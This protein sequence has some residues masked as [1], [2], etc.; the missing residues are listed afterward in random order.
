MSNNKILNLIEPTLFDQT[1]HSYGYVQSL[2]AA[3]KDLEFDL[4]IWLD[5]RGKSLLENSSCKS[6]PY[7]YRPLRQVQKL[8]LYWKLNRRAEIIFISTT[9]LWDLKILRFY[10]KYF[11][12]RA[13]IVLH[14]HQFKQVPAKIKYLQQIAADCSNIEILVPTQKLADFFKAQGFTQCMVI[15]CPTFSPKRQV[16]NT[17]AQFNKILYAGAARRDKGFPT[18]VSLLQH[19]REQKN[20]LPFEIQVSAPNSQRY[21]SATQ[22]ALQSLHSINKNSLTLHKETLDQLQYLE[23]F[24]NAICLLLYD[25]KEYKDKFSG[26]ALDAFYAG[27]PIITAKNTWM[28]DTCEKYGAGIALDNYSNDGIQA[29]IDTIVNNYALYHNNAKQAAIELAKIHDPKN[30][31]MYI[32]NKCS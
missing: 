12:S 2:I 26:I 17:V 20:Y 18:V 11:K 15:P 16:K 22:E 8:F 3:N 13:K 7:F 1:G 10:S 19:F 30:T 5:K 27:C 9:E 4:N 14:F 6:H 21:D 32:S 31:L 23:L 29:A 25:Q 24:N 28:G